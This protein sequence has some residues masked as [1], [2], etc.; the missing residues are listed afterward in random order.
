M[1]T[2]ITAVLDNFGIRNQ[3]LITIDIFSIYAIY[4]YPA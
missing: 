1:R 4:K 2:G 3:L